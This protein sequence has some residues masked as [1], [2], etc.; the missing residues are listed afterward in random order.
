MVADRPY[1]VMYVDDD[2]DLLDLGKI[3]LERTGD[4]SVHCVDSAQAAI[5]VLGNAAFDAIISDYQMPGMDGIAFLKSLRT[6]GSGIPFVIFTG[7]GREEV[8]IDTLNAGADFYLQKGGDPKVQFAELAHKVR[9]A[10]GKRRAEQSLIESKKRLADI[11]DFLPDA[12]F[13][14]DREGSVIAWNRA[15][16]EMTGT[17]AVAVLGRGNQ[18][19]SRAFYG[20]LRPMLIDLV[21]SPD[22]EF[23]REHY[24]FTQ[25]NGTFL[26]AETTVER[27]NGSTTHFWGKACR[28]YD[29]DGNLVGAIEAI[30]DITERVVAEA[31]IREKT[32]ELDLFFQNA[33]DLLCIADTDGYFRKLNPEWERT[34]G[35]PLD[36]LEGRSFMEFV[37]PDDRASTRDAV[38]RL[39]RGEIIPNFVNR[40][41]T[42]D[43]GY[44]WIEWRSFPVGTLIYAIARDITDRLAIQQALAAS[45]EKYRTL[46]DEIRDGFFMTDRDGIL[47][48]ANRTLA[49]MFGFSSPDEMR[50]QHFSRF[51]AP[52][53]HNRVL[54]IFQ[55]CIETGRVPDFTL[56]IEAVRNDGGRFF[57][58]LKAA[59]VIGDGRVQGTRGIIRDISDRRKADEH[60]RILVQLLD[61]APASITVHDLEGNFLYA[62]Q[63]TLDLHGYTRDEFLSMNL[64]DLDVPES[65]ALIQARIEKIMQTGESDF[66]VQHFKKDGTAVPL[67]VNTLLTEWMG[68]KVLLSIATDLTERLAAQEE[69][70]KSE[71]KYRR[72]V[73]TAHEG[74]WA[75]DEHFAT[76]YVNRRMAEILGYSPEEMIGRPIDSF[77]ADEEKDIQRSL[78]E[79][80]MRGLPGKYERTFV[81]RSGTRRIMYVSATPLLDEK[82][83]FRGSFAMLTDI[84][85]EKRIQKELAREHDELVA[86]YEQI[87]ATEEELRQML[88]D[89]RQHQ[90][91]LA[92]SEERYRRLIE[93][94][95]DA[96]VIHRE[97]RIIYANDVAVRLMG[98]SDRAEIVGKMTLD[99]VHPDSRDDVRVRIARMTEDPAAVMPPLE[100]K[101]ITLSGKVIDVEVIAT[102][103]KSEGEPAFLVIFRDISEK[104]RIQ[105]ALVQA[106]RKLNLL[107]SITRH[108]I[109]N[110]LSVLAGHI[111]LARSFA[112]DEQMAGCLDRQ[113]RAVQSIRQ[114]LEFTR[115]YEELGVKEPLWQHFPKT[116]GKVRDQVDM[117]SVTLHSEDC[118]FEIFADPLLEKVFYALLDNAARYGGKITR[119]CASCSIADDSLVI[120]IQDDGVGIPQ[121]EK[122]KIFEK[123]YGKGTGLGLF[124]SREI[125][126]I[127]G[128]TIRETGVPGRGVRF[129]IVV[130]GGMWR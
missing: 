78:L 31:E 109:S 62:N 54:P 47:T 53:E 29:E 96:M 112:M 9:Q 124:L 55:K 66:D 129:E 83:A 30:R 58:E 36:E 67:H 122:E 64:H 77:M 63:R 60:L 117:G 99:F 88:D 3:F 34:L 24:H 71:E 95:F 50:G 116:L 91:E 26:T 80:R 22:Q 69:I 23:E 41:R 43:G 28:L 74:I 48:F 46:V 18:V 32:R 8:V 115:D 65:E 87:A 5:A 52:G 100:E 73:E 20:T 126:S 33:I 92:E 82:G 70:R 51:M 113:N 120:S 49:E 13:A 37:H 76:T 56:E 1:S 85:E 108:D 27:E 14:I 125:L 72:I 79:E 110:K 123:G 119:V 93:H 104:K 103:T 19:Y 40:Y 61:S 35:Y 7:K 118:Q 17:P 45:E 16:E 94:S 121:D 111:S 101:F 6:R 106:N 10:I 57:M 11:I 114:I 127:T 130:P 2:Q 21:L 4:F 107:S 44:R 97:G 39:G 42:R 90:D 15:M 105:N 25:R 84:T 102:A 86:S 38:A 59:L 89:L 12:T 68:K 75:M 98:A 128:M 81:T